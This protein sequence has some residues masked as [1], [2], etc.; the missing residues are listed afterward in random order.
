MKGIGSYNVPLSPVVASKLY[1][2]VCAPKLTYGF[3]VMDINHTSRDLINTF[4]VHAAKNIQGLPDQAANPGSLATVGWQSMS[5]FVD[6][7]RLLFLWRILLLPMS[8]IYKAVFIR[9][10]LHLLQVQKAGIGPVW[11]SLQLCYKYGIAHIVINAIE[12]GEYMDMAKWK[13]LVKSVVSN[14]DLKS[15]KATCSLYNSLKYLNQEI[16]HL[17]MSTWWQHSHHNPGYARKNRTVIQLLLN[18]DRQGPKR[19]VLCNQHDTREVKHILFECGSLNEIR[20][21][22][23]N[24]VIIQGPEALMGE[25]QSMSSMDRCKFVLNG[26][27]SVYVQEWNN[28]YCS[29]SDFVVTIYSAYQASTEL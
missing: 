17:Q 10:F 9:R 20:N 11:T 8:C 25:F 24:N 1:W 19:C 22:L 4:H 12:S 15:W 2:D 6:R 23:W 13:M 16:E 28:L 27:N 29:L 18:K 14:R 7:L 26:L 3:E 21:T 5:A